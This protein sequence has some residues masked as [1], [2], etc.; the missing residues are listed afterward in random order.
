MEVKNILL[1]TLTTMHFLMIVNPHGI[2]CVVC[3][4]VCQTQLTKTRR[5]PLLL[6]ERSRNSLA[7][8]LLPQQVKNYLPVMQKS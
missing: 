3:H 8:S 6:F 7:H 4:M 1:N 2:W 5:Y